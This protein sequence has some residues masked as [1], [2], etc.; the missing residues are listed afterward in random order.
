MV[1]SSY[2]RQIIPPGQRFEQRPLMRLALDALIS[3]LV[4]TSTTRLK[5]R[6][7]RGS[8]CLNPLPVIKKFPTVLFNLT[9]TEP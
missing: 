8:P 5:R 7:E 2:W 9:Q 4:K 1:S 3:I 6:G